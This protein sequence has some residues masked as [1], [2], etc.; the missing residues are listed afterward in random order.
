MAGP[1][2][3]AIKVNVDGSAKGSPGLS[4]AGGVLRDGDAN[5]I[6]GFLYKVGISH[7]ITSELWAIYHGLLLSWG[8]GFRTVLLEMD[9]LKARKLIKGAN[10]PGNHLLRL[11]SAIKEL[12]GRNWE[13]SIT[14]VP[15]EANHCAD[16]IATHF[17]SYDLGLHIL[18]E[19]SL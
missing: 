15:R 4:A 5:W 6:C 17:D 11:V 19:A 18:E 13:I 3:G 10:L 9:S 16:W 7:A 12:L 14:Y 8:K 1:A 2:T